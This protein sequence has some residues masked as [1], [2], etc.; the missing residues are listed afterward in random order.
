M[1]KYRHRTFC[2][3]HWILVV[4][5]C[6]LYVSGYYRLEFTT[7]TESLNWYLLVMHMN[8]GLLVVVFTLFILFFKQ[9]NSVP[10]EGK[11]KPNLAIKLM[12]KLVH[13]G[14]YAMLL[15]IPVAAYV[16]LGFDFP[17][18][19]LTNFPGLMR[20]EWIHEWVNRQF[21][22]PLIT[23]MEPFSVFHRNIGSDYILP[24][25]IILHITGALF[26]HFMVRDN[27][28]ANVLPI[29]NRKMSKDR[30]QK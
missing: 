17:L 27:I 26:H 1:I 18:L 22:V 19:G 5:V 14:L 28:L 13:F 15:A 23:F 3:L 6:F 10:E 20:F 11:V 16:G 24:S 4:L 12:G 8:V 7:Q 30:F 25:L 9:D 2:Y 29:L 21:Q